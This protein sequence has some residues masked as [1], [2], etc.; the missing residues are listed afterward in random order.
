MEKK[1]LSTEEKKVL[2]S[3]FFRSHL[4]FLSFNMVKMEANGFTATM[5][6]AIESIYKDDMEGKKEAYL[7]HQNFFNT[8]AVPFSFIAGLA[9]AMEKEHKEKNSI[10]GQTIDSIKAA[11]MGPTAGMFDSLF[12][13]CL[14]IIAAGIGIGLCS[15]GNILGTIIFI[16]MYGV[17]QS[18]FKYFFVNWGYT[19]GTTFIDSVF[20][21]GL[22][23]ALTKSASVLGLMMVGAMTAQMVNVPL[24][25]TLNVGQTSVVV[26][27]VINS[28]FPGL[29][30]VLLLFLLVSLIK[31]GARPT[32]L[33]IGIFVFALLGGFIGIF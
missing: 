12:F 8:H 21:S 19:Y 4:V 10:D 6:P 28:I 30:G 27:D 25:W 5:A 26:A 33:I 22:M 24:N 9:Y 2:R 13:N 3:M 16:L 29:L 32:Q 11:L 17:S 20:S 15:Q 7:R 18:V 14:R 1:I 31:K 23:G